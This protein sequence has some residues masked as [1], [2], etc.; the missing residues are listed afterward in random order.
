E[1][2][3][4]TDSGTLTI[5]DADA[6][7]NP[8]SFVDEGPTAGDNGYGTFEM[9]GNTWTYTLNNSLA[10][11]QELDAG[12]TLSDTYSFTATDS[13]TQVVTVT[14]SGAEDGMGTGTPPDPDPVDPDPIDPDPVDPD[15][16]DPAPVD[17]DPTD[18]VD[19]V[20]EPE[21]EVTEDVVVS[22]EAGTEVVAEETLSEDQPEGDNTTVAVES[23]DSSDKQDEST[24]STQRGGDAGTVAQDPEIVLLNENGEVIPV[25]SSVADGA[26]AVEVQERQEQAVEK[27]KEESMSTTTLL[28]KRYLDRINFLDEASYSSAITQLHDALDEFREEAASQEQ[29]YKTVIGSAIAVSTGLS[30]GYVV[31]LIRGGMLLSSMLF[32]IPAWQLADP[33]PLLASRR[34]DEE[35]EETLETIIKRRDED[36][37]GEVEKTE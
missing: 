10:A 4:L 21:E 9:V 33:L 24:A 16:V 26:R 3:S 25:D 2:G 11:V 27:D 31:W 13:S 23:D 37:G 29:Y 28:L 14:I 1:D 8:I 17:P 20:E 32:S 19:P 6:S 30:V 15:P 5:S 12:E 36:I 7:D 34:H 35:D 22:E 18:P